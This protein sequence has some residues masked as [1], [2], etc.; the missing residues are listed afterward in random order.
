MFL[1]FLISLLIA[2]FFS[3]LLVL[4]SYAIL[5]F[6]A[7]I[8][9]V[10]SHFGGEA[11]VVQFLFGIF[12]LIAGISERFYF[13]LL[14]GQ[15]IN[16]IGVISLIVILEAFFRYV[17]MPVH[18]K[19]KHLHP[20]LFR[21]I[22]LFIFCLLLVAPFS[23][24]FLAS[25]RGLNRILSML[26][27]YLI[28]YWAVISDQRNYEKIIN[29]ICFLFIALSIVGLIEYCFGFNFIKGTSIVSSI[30]KNLEVAGSFRRVSATFLT[31]PTYSF[32]LITFLPLYIYQ[33]FL[34]RKSILSAIGLL[35]L[36]INLLFTFTRISWIAFLAEVVLFIILFKPKRLV[37]FLLIMSPLSLI[38]AAQIL[39]RLTIDSSVDLRFK[40]FQYGW[41]LFRENMLFG[42]GLETFL[43][44]SQYVFKKSIAAHGD[45]M[46]IFAE[47]GLIGGL[48]YLY[49]L[50]SN[51]R[52]ALKNLKRTA[53]A[54]VSIISLSGYLIFSI[55][56]NALAYSHIFWGLIAIY[57]ALIAC[58]FLD[59]NTAYTTES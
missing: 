39:N 52:F 30:Y 31:S 11:A 9:F 19:W 24:D 45:Y 46:R 16:L 10:L 54:K 20:G 26:A 32:A 36:M 53:F 43:K 15:S 41:S 50:W 2:F 1:P 28:A 55:T 27:F 22:A 38:F 5:A 51:V 3:I 23:S 29:F 56:D 7:V 35:L 21:P 33:Y 40:L 25:C 34:K 47:T 37:I 49:F 44:S 12:I 14:G 48:A 17:G 58:V 13:P 6:F 4:N 59:T 18:L 42:H 57:N 8:F